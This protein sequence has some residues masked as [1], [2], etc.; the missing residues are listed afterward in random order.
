MAKKSAGGKSR[1]GSQQRES[2][3]RSKKIVAFAKRRADGTF[4]EIDNPKRSIPADVRRKAK[5][6]VTA[7]YGDQ[8][9]QKRRSAG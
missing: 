5:K 4:K 8:G 2:L 1:R 3:T 7:G 9:D 6:R